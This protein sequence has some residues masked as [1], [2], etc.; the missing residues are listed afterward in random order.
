MLRNIEHSTAK[1]TECN[2]EVPDKKTYRRLKGSSNSKGNRV[3]SMQQKRRQY[4]SS[5]IGKFYFK[6]NCYLIFKIKD[7]KRHS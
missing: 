6:F 3:K 1:I 5:E 4:R 2:K 7:L